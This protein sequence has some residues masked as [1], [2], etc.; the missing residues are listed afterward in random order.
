MSIQRYID[1]LKDHNE[2]ESFCDT[3]KQENYDDIE[4]CAF[5]NKFYGIDL[6]LEELEA[7]QD[8]ILN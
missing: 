7:F 4:M 3:I 6:T 2:Y 1:D 5:I 8:L